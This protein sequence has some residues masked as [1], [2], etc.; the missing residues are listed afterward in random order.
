MSG[1]R[2]F[3]QRADCCGA[4]CDWK[5]W[6]QR[7]N[8]FQCW[9]GQCYRPATPDCGHL[10]PKRVCQR[11]DHNHRNGSDLVKSSFVNRSIRLGD[12]DP[13]APNVSA[14]ASA[15]VTINLDKRRAAAVV[16]EYSGVLT[17]GPLDV[18]ATSA[19]T[20]TAAVTGTTATTIQAN[21][22]WIGGIGFANSSFTLGSI[23]N[24]FTP[25]NNTSSINGTAGNN[26]RVYALQKIVTA[27]GAAS[28]GGTISS[29][30]AWSGAIATFQSTLESGTPLVLGGS[31][32]NNYTLTGM[33]GSMTITPKALN[34]TGISAANKIY[35]GTTAATFT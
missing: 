23:A 1:R 3:R 22:L 30:V 35:D 10:D 4:K 27:A 14:G 28:S 31:A 24:G 17:V 32:A 6:S 13:Y 18:T 9:S 16:M 15:T 8:D 11:R 25:V 33:S 19:A 2:R 20:G 21:E 5:R 7:G 12:R 34:Y 26:A 29:S